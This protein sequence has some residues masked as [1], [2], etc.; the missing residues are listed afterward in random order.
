MVW[1]CHDTSARRRS[2]QK[3]NSNALFSDGG[4]G[5]CVALAALSLS[6]SLSIYLTRFRGEHTRGAKTLSV[7]MSEERAKRR[8]MRARGN[9]Q[10]T[11]EGCTREREMMM[12]DK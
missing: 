9:A 10:G 7:G 12:R 2:Q 4:G 11:T 3:S 6:L 5:W 8:L 1:A